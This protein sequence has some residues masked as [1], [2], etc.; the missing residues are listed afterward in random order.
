[1]Y[2]CN[3]VIVKSNMDKNIFYAILLFSCASLAFAD[4]LLFKETEEMKIG[5]GNGLCYSIE[6]VI[7]VKAGVRKLYVKKSCLP[8]RKLFKNEQL[9][10]IGLNSETIGMFQVGKKNANPSE[11]MCWCLLDDC[12]KMIHPRTRLLSVFDNA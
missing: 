10:R 3:L 12:V 11:N 5:R 7:H 6:T 9:Q 4:V 2:I 8:P 1:M